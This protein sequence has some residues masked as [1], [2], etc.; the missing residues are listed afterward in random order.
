MP[1]LLTPFDSRPESR[2][3]RSNPGWST[4][5]WR[6]A[7]TGWWCSAARANFK[8]IDWDQRSLAI[9]TAVEASAGKAPVLAGAGLPNLKATIDQIKSAAAAGADGCLVTPPYYFPIDQDAIVE[10]FKALIIASPVPIMYYHFPGMTKLVAEPDTVVQM[11]DAGLAGIKDSG[12]Q[13]GYLQQVLAR[14]AD[15]PNFR[16]IVGG[17]AHFLAALIHGVDGTIGLQPS[18]A[19]EIDARLF[20]AF[21]RAILTL[22]QTGSAGPWRLAA[23]CW[24]DRAAARPKARPC[25]KDWGFAGGPSRRRCKRSRIRKP[26]IRGRGSKTSCKARRQSVDAYLIQ[27]R[28]IPGFGRTNPSSRSLRHSGLRGGSLLSNAKITRLTRNDANGI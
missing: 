13:I 24:M 18:V 9:S 8:S 7:R 15:D 20:E 25:W 14:L 22:R 4:S 28:R 3:R 27:R 16:V 12:G 23:R 19:P 21:W 5:C 17:D 1:A 11:R 2:P 10:W 6:V 26:T